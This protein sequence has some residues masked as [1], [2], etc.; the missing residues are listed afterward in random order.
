M[1]V[2]REVNG[3][4]EEEGEGRTMQGERENERRMMDSVEGRV[5]GPEGE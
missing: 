1:S 3:G 2:G 5:R 4:M